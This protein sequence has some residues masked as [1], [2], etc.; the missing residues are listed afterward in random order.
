MVRGE[1]FHTLATDRNG[2]AYISFDNSP[3]VPG[4]VTP[5]GVLNG[6]TSDH[7]N[8]YDFGVNH[9]IVTDWSTHRIP[10]GLAIWLSGR[11]IQLPGGHTT[12]REVRGDRR[13]VV[14]VISAAKADVA[15]RRVPQIRG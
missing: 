1:I 5:G 15:R 2:T 7:N 11:Q 14:G 13:A 12:V 3:L 4:G 9:V 6:A 8:Q 10:T